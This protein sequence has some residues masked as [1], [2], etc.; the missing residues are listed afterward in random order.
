MREWFCVYTRT[1]NLFVFHAETNV[2]SFLI[3]NTT[4]S[5]RPGNEAMLLLAIELF[6][7]ISNFF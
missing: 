6:V 1:L 2:F 4:H 5:F 3:E 7:E